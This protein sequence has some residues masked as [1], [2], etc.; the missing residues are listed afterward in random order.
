MEGQESP[1]AVSDVSGRVGVFF[2]RQG[3]L[4]YGTG[5]SLNRRDAELLP[6]QLGSTELADGRQP[7]LSLLADASSQRGGDILFLT[8]FASSERESGKVRRVFLRAIAGGLS[9]LEARVP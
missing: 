6:L 5:R 7:H 9:E 4:G 8:T 2:H 3:K 1:I